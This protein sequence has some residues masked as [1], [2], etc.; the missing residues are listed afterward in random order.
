MQ[1]APIKSYVEKAAYISSQSRWKTR[2]KFTKQRLMTEEAMEWQ[3][4]ETAPKGHITENV[5][6]RGSSDWF[7]A[8]VAVKFGRG[9]PDHH[10]IVR[11]RPWPQDDRW[12]DRDTATYSPDYFDA[13]QSR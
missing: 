8:R 2:Q 7:K 11:R 5:G 6:C 12:E 1:L 4:M 9:N 3:P 10:L 13:W